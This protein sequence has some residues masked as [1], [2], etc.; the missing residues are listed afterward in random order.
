MKRSIAVVLIL[1][2]IENS[3]RVLELESALA[4]NGMI[5][6]GTF[7]SPSGHVFYRVEVLSIKTKQEDVEQVFRELGFQL[8]GGNA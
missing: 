7:N 1:N 2:W 5:P 6:S 4:R 3:D 8:G